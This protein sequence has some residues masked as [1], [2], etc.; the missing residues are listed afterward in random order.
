MTTRADA[1][2]RATAVLRNAGI[3]SP[4]REARLLLAHL[5]KVRPENALD[6]PEAPAPEPEYT[7][8]IARR[9]AHEPVAY[10]LGRREF[11]S[12]DFAVSPATLIPRPDS[13]TL[14]QAALDHLSGRPA[15]L[16]D[17]GTGSGCLLLSVLYARPKAW[18]IGI[19]RIA[20]ATALARQNAASLGLGSRALFVTADWHYALGAKFDLILANPPYIPHGDIAT[21]EPD[22][23]D[24]E[25]LSALDG[26]ADGLDAYRVIIGALPGLLR[27]NGKAVLEI[28][29]GQLQPVTG[30][31]TSLGLTVTSRRDLAGIPRAVI[32]M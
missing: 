14:I 2:T 12:L 28:G 18:G 24:Y 6:S 30:I 5:L 25:P 22:V 7:S 26:G 8:L 21:L 19:D 11:W 23:R 4:R 17:L 3:D 16:L 1:L 31:A 29:I 27:R 15:R 13:E 9:A 10:L 32:I 20:A